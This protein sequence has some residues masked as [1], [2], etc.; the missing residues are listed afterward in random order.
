LEIV[1]QVV[2]EHQV[3]RASLVGQSVDRPDVEGGRQVVIHDVP[4]TDDD[5]VMLSEYIQ[6]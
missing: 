3:E 5:V 1:H 4:L 6:A 2:A